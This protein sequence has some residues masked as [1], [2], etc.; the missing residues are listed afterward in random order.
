M[1]DYVMPVGGWK[2]FNQFFVRHT[3]PGHR[4]VAAI[5]DD[6]I[7]TSPA[8]STYDGQWEVN[9]Y[10]KV[11]IKGLEWSVQE[12]REGPEYKDDFAGGIWIHQFPNTTDY[13]RQ[14]APVGGKVLEARVLQGNAYLGVEAVPAEGD[15]KNRTHIARR[16]LNALD[17]AGYQFQQMRGLIVIQSAIG[18]VAILP[19]G[20]AQVSSIVVTDEEGTT[21]RK[22]E[23]ISYFQFGGSDIV[24]VFGRAS[25]VS[26][27]AQPDVHCNFGT[28]IAEAFPVEE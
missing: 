10:S 17:E 14:R 18:K 16:K 27:T 1:N 15:P 9:A 6:H 3:K 23:E 26:I 22:G 21:L 13:H 24:M 12:L 28:R 2:T 20:M 25:N 19:M 4:P 8:G 5:N 7:I 11:N